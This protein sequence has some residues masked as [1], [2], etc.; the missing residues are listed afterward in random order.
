MWKPTHFQF[1]FIYIYPHC[2]KLR[3][4]GVYGPFW[5]NSPLHFYGIQSIMIFYFFGPNERAPE[6]AD[7]R[8]RWVR[9]AGCHD[10][11][12]GG[13]HSA[14]LDHESRHLSVPR[15]LGPAAIMTPFSLR[16]IAPQMYAATAHFSSYS[17]LG[18]RS[19]L[20]HCLDSAHFHIRGG[21]SGRCPPNG[22][23]GW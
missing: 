8:W 3:F 12:G 17:G 10:A 22:S 14:H 19:A 20:F 9:W 11:G 21:G 7:R 13:R 1:G 23:C 18:A 2:S 6:V 5:I 4:C 15:Q 16:S